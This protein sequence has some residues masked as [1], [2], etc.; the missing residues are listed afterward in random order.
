M[1]ESNFMVVE[2]YRQFK[3]KAKEKNKL[4]HDR[5]YAIM[6]KQINV[7]PNFTSSVVKF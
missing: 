5:F 6:S 2:R 3:K 4:Q 7:S 1:P